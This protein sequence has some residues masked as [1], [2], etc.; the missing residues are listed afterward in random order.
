MHTPAFWNNHSKGEED[1]YDGGVGSA[2]TE[3][4]EPSI[5]KSRFHSDLDIVKC[6]NKPRRVPYELILL[7]GSISQ[8]AVCISQLD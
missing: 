4:E 6:P 1:V 7:V 2:S 5:P 3:M 8:P